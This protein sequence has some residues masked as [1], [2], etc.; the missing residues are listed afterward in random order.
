[1]LR[2]VEQH[3]L[4]LHSDRH[5]RSLALAFE[6]EMA[7][8]AGA[9]LLQAS[10]RFVNGVLGGSQRELGREPAP[11]VIREE[12][13]RAFASLVLRHQRDVGSRENGVALA[14]FQ[15]PDPPGELLALRRTA[16]EIMVAG[17]LN[18]VVDQLS[19][20]RWV[21][22]L[23]HLTLDPSP[24]GSLLRGALLGRRPSVVDLVPVEPEWLV[25]VDLLLEIPCLP[26]IKGALGQLALTSA[27]GRRTADAAG[28]TAIVPANACPGEDVTLHGS[29]FGAQQPGDT[30]VRVATRNGRCAPAVIRTWSDDAI[31][32]TLPAEVGSGC[33][34]FVRGTGAPI[35]GAAAEL[36]GELE[37]CLGPA[38]AH[39]AERVRQLDAM[40][41]PCPPCLP[42]GQNR[43]SA[44]LPEVVR[45]AATPGA[46]EPGAHVTVAWAT[47]GATKVT[48]T[49][50][51]QHGPLPVLPASLP[52]VGTVDLGPFLG[53]RPAT[54][55]YRLEASNACGSTAATAVVAL[56]RLPDLAITSVEV[57]QS[58]QRADNSVRLVA[59]KRTAVRVYVNSGVSDGFDWGAGPDVVPGLIGEVV[60]R[61]V[62]QPTGTSSGPPWS[63]GSARGNHS[64]DQLD[65]SLNFELP[66]AATTGTV[67]LDVTV[68]VP[69]NWGQHDHRYRAHTTLRVQFNPSPAQEML[70]L[71][72]ADPVQG[73][74]APSLADW[75]AVLDGALSRYPI[76]QTGF[77]VNPPLHLSTVR[78]GATVW[79]LRTEEG[80]VG[81]IADLTTMVFLFPKSP[82][83]G[84]RAGVTPEHR[85]YAWAGMAVPRVAVTVP[86]FASQRRRRASFAHELGHCMGVH[87]ADCGGPRPPLDSRLPLV[88]EEP[89]MQLAFRSVARTGSHELMSYCGG[90]GRWVSIAH[91]DIAAAELPIT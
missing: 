23:L 33:I 65:H 78:L 87:H 31:V 13:A 35:G 51:S 45:F 46:V 66:L 50:T 16:G 76:A 11:L 34:G 5:L 71:L 12:G 29:G 21:D 26:G 30:Q 58:I 55:T 36:A 47:T 90:E 22:A 44:G 24:Y 79:D 1:M 61:P 6:R 2:D 17:A 28:I 19:A 68:R 81:M 74:P 18:P 27:S 77:L 14:L 39:I 52:P 59:G 49:R 15:P 67:D 73:L 62:G 69:G 60:A 63:P 54:A 86:A 38:V 84:V 53:A 56:R 80:W 25:P 57:V 85:D 70:P 64:R 32:V 37:H 20:P 83:G 91:Y 82:V 10:R 8:G 40:P 9:R 7:S 4:E 42:G 89:G 88:T 41:P 48:L 3:L 75:F 72:I 43:I